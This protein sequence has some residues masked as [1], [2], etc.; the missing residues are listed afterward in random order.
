MS[1]SAPSLTFLG[2]AG[3]VTGSKTLLEIGDARVLVDCGLFQGRKELRLANWEAFPVPPES[4]DAVVLTHAHIDHCGYLPR[5]YRYGY[6][7]PVVATPG[8]RALAGIVLPDSGHLHEEEAAYANRMG[9][10]KHHPA[11][12]L[13]TAAEARAC[14]ELFETVPFETAR[15][16]V[17]GV[18][19]TWRRA[20]H[21]LG[22]ASLRIVVADR[23]LVFSGVVLGTF[24]G[25]LGF[26]GYD[27]KPVGK[28]RRDPE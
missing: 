28:S 12:P 9:Y 19:V 3:T 13:Y 18:D 7:G 15:S 4:I 20:G 26:F 2:G 22:A 8:T 14:L 27:I 1:M 10:S 6:R 24:V 21:I 25:N 17:D 23:T 16:V 5:L 11:E